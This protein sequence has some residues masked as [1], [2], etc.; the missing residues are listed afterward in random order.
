MAGL[1]IPDPGTNRKLG[2]YKTSM[3]SGTETYNLQ[4]GRYTEDWKFDHGDV[5]NLAPG[6]YYIDKKKIDVQNGASIYGDGVTI[7]SAGNN[8]VRFHSTGDIQL[9]PPT[10]GAYA[11]ITLFKDPTAKGKITFE[12]DANLNISGAIYAPSSL[13]RFQ[14]TS[15]SMG[16]D[17]DTSAWD[18]LSSDLNDA[19]AGDSSSGNGSL[20][21]SIIA[22]MLKLD[23]GSNITITGA[24]LN[25]Q[26]PLLGLVE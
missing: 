5:V 7:Y 9:S 15:A 3:G 6:T 17:A 18:N 4:P 23:E 13:V 12:K 20:G 11:G 16:D 26:R 25:L 19:P 8:E 14:K 2:D 1:A 24:A 10:S 21:A 22:D